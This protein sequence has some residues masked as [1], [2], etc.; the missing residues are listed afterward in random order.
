IDSRGPGLFVQERVGKDGRTFTCYKFRTMN[1][2]TVEA[3]T[4]HIPRS[5]VTRLGRI[6]RRPKL[7][8]L[9]QI[10]NILRNEMSLVGPRPSLPLQVELVEARRRRGVLE[11][12]PG[13]TGLA[14]INSVDMSNPEALAKWD[15]RYKALQSIKLDMQI[16]IK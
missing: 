1:I 3:P 8:E 6:L 13:I 11:L 7:D 4:H 5:A 14:Q 2:D 12:K 9:P 15:A 10:W 16:L